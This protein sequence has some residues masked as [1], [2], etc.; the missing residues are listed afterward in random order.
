MNRNVIKQIK[1]ASKS[2]V[3]AISPGDKNR[4]WKRVMIVDDD[5]DITTTFKIGIENANFDTNKIIGVQTYNDPRKVL[6]DFPSNF[7]DL[8][9]IDINMPYVD[10]FQLSEAILNIDLNVRICYMSSGEINRDALREV[11]PSISLG[12]FIK[13]PITIDRLVDR[14]K[15]ELD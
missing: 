13:K 10:G 14:I 2:S 8:V 12:C 3:E 1:Y 15:L 4:F 11:H 7:Y 6:L 9:L 5:P